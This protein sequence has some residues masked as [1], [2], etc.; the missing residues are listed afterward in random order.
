MAEVVIA[1]GSNLGDRTAMLRQAAAALEKLSRK[2]IETSSAWQSA[3]VGPAKYPF[4]NSVATLTTEL[5][6]IDLLHF[7]K[8]IEK[9][10][11]RDPAV[12]RWGPRELDLDIISW[13]SLAMESE[14]LIIPHPEYRQRLFVLL[15][16]QELRPEWVDPIDQTPIQVLIEQADSLEIE[17]TDISWMPS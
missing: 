17:R 14:K 8:N 10:V 13:G 9:R 7:L 2:P 3:P 16:L 5:L 4:L 6:P 1:I 11:G 15:P 12:P